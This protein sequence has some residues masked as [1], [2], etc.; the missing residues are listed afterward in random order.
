MMYTTV[1]VEEKTKHKLE[2]LKEYKRETF[3]ELLNRLADGYPEVKDEL[4]E[5]IVKGAD[6]YYKQGIKHRFSSSED[7]RKLIE[8]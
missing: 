1:R 7:L 8:G 3:D 6:E 4:V 5:E 2:A